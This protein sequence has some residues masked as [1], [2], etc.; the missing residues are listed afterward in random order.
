MKK[1]MMFLT[2]I[3]LSVSA[4]ARNQDHKYHVFGKL[5]MRKEVVEQGTDT[6]FD[7][8]ATYRSDE[9]AKG[10]GFE[11]LHDISDKYTVA[12]GLEYNFDQ[13]ID[14]GVI[15]FDTISGAG[16]LDGVDFQSTSLNVNFQAKVINEL[17]LIGGI[18]YDINKL[19]GIERATIDDGLGLN[20]GLAFDINNFRTQA[21]YKIANHDVDAS[22]VDGKID[23]LGVHLTFCFI[24]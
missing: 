12:F 2:T 5:L 20:F 8:S 23:L 18:R 4:N 13:S 14:M 17:Y 10:I 6:G 21:V 22:D 11:Y 24:L 9:Y 16:K 19:S 15:T 3:L 1:T 7:Y